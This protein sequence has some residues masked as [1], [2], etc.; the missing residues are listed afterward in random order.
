MN[1]SLRA[2]VRDVKIIARTWKYLP[3]VNTNE[4]YLLIV[5]N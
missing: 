4:C 2:E 3:R 1:L 5:C